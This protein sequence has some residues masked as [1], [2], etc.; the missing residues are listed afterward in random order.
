MFLNTNFLNLKKT[1]IIFFLIVLF[2]ISTIT[3]ANSSIFKVGDIEITEPFNSNFKKKKVID[4]AII[5]A[6]EKLLRMTI[7]SNEKRKISTIGVKE[8]RNLID[9]FNIKNEKFINDIYN[10]TFEINFNKQ[11]TFL[12][13]EKKNI[14]PS[15]PIV[16]N[17]I[18]MPILVDIKSQSLSIFNQ[19][20]FY[21]Y[22]NS[23]IKSYHL[24]DYILPAED[25][26]VVQILNDNI[27]NL[28]DYDFSQITRSYNTNDYIICL[29]Y[30]DKDAF[31]VFSKI[32]FN[33]KFKIKS[34]I[35]SRKTSLSDEGLVNL[36]NQ[37][38]LIYEDEWKEINKINRSVKL[39]IN[40]S[41][42]SLEF[43]KNHK[44][45]RFLSSTDQVSEYSIK[46]FN[47]NYVNYKII[48]NGSPKQ[49]LSAAEK[50]NFFIDTKKQIWK[51]E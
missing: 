25:I 10:A 14:Y 4:K 2:I 6:F 41:I 22:W 40:L 31:N 3:K 20:P 13:I 33:N 9:S 51:V 36:I 15:V 1:Y 7:P 39:P 18:V 32:K 30:K 21:T 27:N 23:H 19:N 49:F 16:R 8:I 29:I 47:N 11:N 34:K 5:L 17:V 50:N 37:I 24:I 45:E 42:S 35:F 12:F 46:S 44:F 43:E 26:D 48:F 38:K 28:E